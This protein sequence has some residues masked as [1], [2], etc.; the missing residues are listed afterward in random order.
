MGATAPRR[1]TM[2]IAS[3]MRSICTSTRRRW[4]ARARSASKSSAAASRWTTGLRGDAVLRAFIAD[5]DLVPEVVPDL[6]IEL[7]EAWLEADL[8]DVP[9]P[10]QVDPVR[11][12]DRSGPRGDHDHAIR[13]ADRLLQ[14]VRH[15][16]DGRAR[17]GPPAEQLVLHDRAALP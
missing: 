14:V 4:R 15:E 8:G 3:A 10:R 16:H 11:S 13:H 12:L 6:F 2:K 7:D 5:Q 17:R 9:R 1:Q